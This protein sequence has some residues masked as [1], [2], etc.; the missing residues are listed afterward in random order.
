[1]LTK[2]LTTNF[3]IINHIVQSKKTRETRE[4]ERDIIFYIEVDALKCNQFLTRN[5]VFEIYIILITLIFFSMIILNTTTMRLNVNPC[6]ALEITKIYKFFIYF[7]KFL[8]NYFS[9]KL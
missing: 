4:R 9:T 8:E 5:F 3:S 6:K 2:K 7:N 1:M